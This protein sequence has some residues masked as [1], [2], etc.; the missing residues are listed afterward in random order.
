MDARWICRLAAAITL[1]YSSGLL[2]DEKEAWYSI[3]GFIRYDEPV[4][5]QK[6]RHLELRELIHD[7]ASREQTP[8]HLGEVA[9][10]LE[11]ILPAP[12][13]DR[14]NSGSWTNYLFGRRT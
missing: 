8:L 9:F 11:R 13:P 5:S 7:A 3:G 6:K 2:A 1:F 4:E 10:N 14:K 12:N